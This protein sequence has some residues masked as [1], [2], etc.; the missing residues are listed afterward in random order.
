MFINEKKVVAL[1]YIF[2]QKQG[3]NIHKIIKDKK[4]SE[5]HPL[6]VDYYITGEDNV[7]SG[8]KEKPET[9]CE[10]KDCYLH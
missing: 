3:S 9:F 1:E 8:F 5:K 7:L 2:Y 10:S 4:R 6:G